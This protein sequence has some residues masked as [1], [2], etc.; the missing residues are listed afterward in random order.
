MFVLQKIK[1]MVNVALCSSYVFNYKNEGGG[2]GEAGICLVTHGNDYQF[3][4]PSFVPL[5]IIS[6]YSKY[7]EVCSSFGP[8]LEIP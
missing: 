8:S 5:D 1:K 7:F 2:G 6:L 4:C 3:A